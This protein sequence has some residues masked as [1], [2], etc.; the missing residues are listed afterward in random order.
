MFLRATVK[1]K[2]SNRV[3]DFEKRQIEC[4]KLTLQTTMYNIRVCA[5]NEICLQYVEFKY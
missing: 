5:V 3:F 2:I 4:N 1:V